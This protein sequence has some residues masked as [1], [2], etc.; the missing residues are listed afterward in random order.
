MGRLIRTI[1]EEILDE[2]MGGVH[3]VIITTAGSHSLSIRSP[4]N[5]QYTETERERVEHDSTEK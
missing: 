1:T 4:V 3:L 5:T 2:N